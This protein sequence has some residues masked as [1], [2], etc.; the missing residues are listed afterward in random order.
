MGGMEPA[1][2][3]IT[4]EVRTEKGRKTEDKQGKMKQ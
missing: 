1:E 3:K 4:V 2:I